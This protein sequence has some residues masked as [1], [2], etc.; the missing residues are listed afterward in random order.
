MKAPLIPV[1]VRK[2]TNDATLVTTNARIFG[3]LGSPLGLASA[4]TP[5]IIG[6]TPI[7][8]ARA[9]AA[10]DA[11]STMRSRKY[12]V[13]SRQLCDRCPTKAEK[14]TAAP[15]AIVTAPTQS[16]PDHVERQA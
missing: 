15:T 11:C 3:S 2:T 1:Y 9:P 7:P 4:A 14:P 12:P 13:V 10:Q 5:A 6:R 16:Q 8:I